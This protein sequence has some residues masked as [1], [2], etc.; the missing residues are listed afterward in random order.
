MTDTSEC[1]TSRIVSALLK[2]M[3]D[4]LILQESRISASDVIYIETVNG[5]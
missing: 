2:L 3:T 4:E 1:D 5:N